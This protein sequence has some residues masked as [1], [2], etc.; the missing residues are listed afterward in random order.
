MID[1]EGKKEV[2]KTIEFLKKQGYTIIYITN[3]IGEILMADRIIILSGGKIVNDFKK[4]DILENIDAF[5]SNNISIP[6]IA[7]TLLKLR[8]NG[9]EINLEKWTKEELDDKIIERLKNEK[10]N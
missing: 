1:S 10:N 5:T 8:E 6:Q 4:I 7:S 3:A 9:I 2:Y